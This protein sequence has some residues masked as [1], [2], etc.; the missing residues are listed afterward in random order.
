MDTATAPGALM[1]AEIR[2]QPERWRD[3]EQELDAIIEAGQWLR[4]G[5][6]TGVVFLARGTSDHAALYGQYLVQLRLGLP[7]S[8]AT[9]AITALNG[10]IPVPAGHAVIALSQSGHSPDL[11]QTL[12][13]EFLLGRDG[14]GV[15]DG[16]ENE[17]ASGSAVR[18]RRGAQR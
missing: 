17:A 13:A 18:R 11:I 1:E 15:D 7:V 4:D 3:L 6:L 12:R 14:P 9:P 2:E 10:A 8:L 16:H 5:G